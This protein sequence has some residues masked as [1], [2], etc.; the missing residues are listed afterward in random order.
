MSQ[1]D[2]TQRAIADAAASEHEQSDSQVLYQALRRH[3]DALSGSAHVPT[4]D[5]ALSERI[6][7][8]ARTR[9]AQI[10]ASRQIP[11]KDQSVPWWLIA[12]WIVAVVAIVAGWLLL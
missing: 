8:E 3:R 10:Q 12:A 2:E 1:P 9:S 5:R 7:A 11:A 4:E 6:F